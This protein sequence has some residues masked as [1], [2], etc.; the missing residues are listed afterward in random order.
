MEGNVLAGLTDTSTFT[1]LHVLTL[2]SQAISLPLSQLVR[3][4]H[5]QLRNGL[6][7]SP[8]YKRLLEHLE[9]IIENPDILVGSNVS[10]KTATFDG[11]P[12]YDPDA[13]ANILRDRDQHPHLQSALVTF[14]EGA[15]ET[16]E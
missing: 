6:D 15:L 5:H 13:V 8:D 4:P 7:L 2:Y 16:W 1:E 12:W 10:W 11:Q 9:T 14:F 3:T